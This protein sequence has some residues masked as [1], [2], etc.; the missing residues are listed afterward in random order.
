MAMQGYQIKNDADYYNQ[1]ANALNV[2]GNIAAS[3]NPYNI[4]PGKWTGAD[5]Q[6]VFATKGITPQS[7]YDQ[8]GKSEGWYK[9]PTA[10]TSSSYKLPQIKSGSSYITPGVESINHLTNII[11]KNSPYIQSA[12][13]YEQDKMSNRG[14]I[15]SSIRAG[16][17][18]RA[19]IDAAAPFALKD[20]GTEALF[21]QQQQNAESQLTRDSA[22]NQYDL[23]KQKA[24]DAAALSRLNV[25]DTAN[26]AREQL[27]QDSATGRQASMN[28]ANLAKQ[29]AVDAAAL[30]RLNVQDTANLA[31]EQLVQDSATGRLN[32]TNKNRINAAL[33]TADAANTRNFNT[34]YGN[35]SQQLTQGLTSIDAMDMSSSD[36]E[37]SKNNLINNFNRNVHT[38]VNTTNAGLSKYKLKWDAVTSIK[39]GGDPV[40]QHSSGLVSTPITKAT[41]PH[42]YIYAYG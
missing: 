12:V 37:S 26:L 15:N 27:V 38:L 19:A 16:A 20:A 21:Q 32:I 2:K 36:K 11:D 40:S 18:T 5:V 35:M 31:K 42:H 34:T 17:E 23:T 24:V 8:W 30:S 3:N 6:N 4:K 33:V 28:T 41:L 14:L 13:N 10:K 25:Q 1:K 7:H 39:A 22:Q 29:K 9:P